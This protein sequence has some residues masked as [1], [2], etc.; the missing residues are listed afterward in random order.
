MGDNCTPTVSSLYP[1]AKADELRQ[2]V[3][4]LQET[5]ER[6]VDRKDAILHSLVRDIEES[7]E[8]YHMSLRSHI[9][10]VDKLIGMCMCMCVSI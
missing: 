1:V 9:E 3:Q 7:E 2:D 5:F 4:V 6:Q 8:Q 10:N